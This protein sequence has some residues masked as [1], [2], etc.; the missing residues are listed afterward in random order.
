MKII[1]FDNLIRISI[2]NI[3]IFGSTLF[4]LGQQ[5]EDVTI[6]YAEDINRIS[7]TPDPTVSVKTDILVAAT[8]PVNIVKPTETPLQ[9][10]TRHNQKNNCWIIYQG[11]IYDITAY[12]GSHPG[13]DQLMLQYCGKDA[14]QAFDSKDNVPPNPHSASA[15]DILQRYRVK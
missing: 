4:F 12:F 15:F 8:P 5:S 14:T 10:V 2:I 7:V 3:L 6:S 13:G 9:K 1:S 11:S